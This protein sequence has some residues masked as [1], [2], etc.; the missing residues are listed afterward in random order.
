MLEKSDERKSLWC[1][2]A[3]RRQIFNDMDNNKRAIALLDIKKS[4]SIDVI[5]RK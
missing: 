2:E 1:R 5:K 4:A 3:L